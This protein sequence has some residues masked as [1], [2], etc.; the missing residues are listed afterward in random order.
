MSKV[1]CIAVKRVFLLIYCVKTQG[2]T[3]YRVVTLSHVMSSVS[4]FWPEAFA[5]EFVHFYA[6]FLSSV[7]EEFVL[8]CAL[9]LT[10]CIC[11]Q[12]EI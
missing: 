11:L 6:S 7:A 9:R 3:I 10:Y 2:V 1:L 8:T 12:Y 5:M 4:N